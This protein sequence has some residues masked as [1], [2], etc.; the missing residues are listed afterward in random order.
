MQN[1]LTLEDILL[2]MLKNWVLVFVIPL[3]FAVLTFTFI[4]L[5]A[6]KTKKQ[7]PNFESSVT[8]KI[9]NVG[10]TLIEPIAFVLKKTADDKLKAELS[11]K[12][13]SDKNSFELFFENNSGF[14]TVR[15]I[16]TS[17][18]TAITAPN[19]IANLIIVRH[20]EIYIEL[21]DK[22][23]SSIKEIEKKI[24]PSYLTLALNDVS[25]EPTKIIS[26]PTTK[27]IEVP[28]TSDNKK[29][30]MFFAVFVS[31]LLLNLMIAFY[32]DGARKRSTKK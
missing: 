17:S 22:L 28:I 14:L 10:S 12:I 3:L 11:N 4:S 25:C 13:N 29:W 9:G 16:S 24:Y 23:F 21:K 31:L 15:T 20:N 19:F 1:E 6:A 18:T 5:S 30:R 32:I 27:L 7:L 26:L 8:L 2:V